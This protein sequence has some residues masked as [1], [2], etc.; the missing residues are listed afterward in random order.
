MMPCESHRRY[1]V[2]C[3]LADFHVDIQEQNPRLVSMLSLLQSCPD[4]N[5][6]TFLYLLHHLQRY[7]STASPMTWLYWFNLQDNY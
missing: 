3:I 6:H 1:S 4:A 7:E 2:N 5:R